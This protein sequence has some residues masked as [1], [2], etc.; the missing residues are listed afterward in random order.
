MLVALCCFQVE[1]VQNPYLYKLYITRKL[2]MDTKNGKS[3]KNEQRLWHGTAPA[4]VPNIN[5]KNFNRS[6]GGVNGLLL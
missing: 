5:A 6:Y 4:S 3:T 2:D 1:R